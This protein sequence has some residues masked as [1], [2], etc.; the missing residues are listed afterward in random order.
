MIDCVIP[1]GQQKNDMMNLQMKRL[2]IVILIGTYITA[3]VPLAPAEPTSTLTPIPSAHPAKAITLM[4]PKATLFPTGTT[5]PTPTPVTPT[6]TT[7]Y[8][9]V[10]WMELNGFLASDHTNWNAYDANTYTCVNFALDLVANAM[11]ENIKAWIV[12][13]QFDRSDT[14]HAF[15]AFNTTDL[16]EVWIEPQ[17]D[18]GYYAVSVGK[19]L[20]YTVDTNICENFGLVTKVEEPVECDGKKSTCWLPRH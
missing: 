11:N 12:A 1:G 15:V 19:P 2:I 20:C 17:S 3:C 13:V 18:Y 6:P 16:G 8:R 9:A 10:D 7:A 5:A 14:G 4:T